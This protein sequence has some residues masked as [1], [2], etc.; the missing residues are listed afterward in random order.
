MKLPNRNNVI[1][2][3]EKLVQYILSETHA[4]GRFKA[5]F[6]LD[7]GFNKTNVQLFENCLRNIA[8]SEDV[9]D[10]SHSPYGIKYVID[11]EVKTPNGKRVKLRT[12]WIIEKGE[13]RPR[14]VT[15]Y[16]V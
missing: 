16:P 6:F 15:I 2:S 14:F 8:K 11:G 1:I 3:R 12:V 5:K 13:M 9:G 7:H 10:A 4:L